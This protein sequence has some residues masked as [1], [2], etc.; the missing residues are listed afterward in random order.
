MA[1]LGAA[2]LVNVSDHLR[3]VRHPPPPRRAFTWRLCLNLAT[4]VTTNYVQEENVSRCFAPRR[5]CDIQKKKKVP[6][7]DTFKR[8]SVGRSLSFV[9]QESDSTLLVDS[10][11]IKIYSVEVHHPQ[12]WFYRE[13]L[14]FSNVRKPPS[15]NSLLIFHKMWTTLVF[16]RTIFTININIYR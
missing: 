13:S 15:K 11:R 14:S 10:F 16:I 8:L 9:I 7:T 6:Q 2:L 1:G 3:N 12:D 4:C 5:F